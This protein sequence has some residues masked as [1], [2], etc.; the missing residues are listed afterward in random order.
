MSAV[1][2]D[3]YPLFG[4]CA[5]LAAVLAAV[6]YGALTCWMCTFLLLNNSHEDYPLWIKSREKDVNK[7][8]ITVL[9]IVSWAAELITSRIVVMQHDHR[10]GI[11]EVLHIL[12]CQ[13]I[14][15]LNDILGRR[16]RSV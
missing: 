9:K 13:S 7:T 16:Q 14:R 11:D 12:N 4:V 6:R 2:R 8:S 5:A 10:P 1:A 3:F 15:G